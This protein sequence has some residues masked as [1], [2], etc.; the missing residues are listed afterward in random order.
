MANLIDEADQVH[1]VTL[2]GFV[3]LDAGVVLDRDLAA[4]T[5]P[6]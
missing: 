2:V 3:Y 6:T 5:T 1:L 4:S